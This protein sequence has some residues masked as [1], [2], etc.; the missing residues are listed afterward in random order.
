MS[1]AQNV[2]PSAD[3][4]RKSR[5]DIILAVVLLL[6]AAASF[7]WWNFSRAEGASVAVLI[8]GVETAEY[9][10]H[11]DR[12]VVITTGDNDEFK[13]V[14]VIRDG[15]VSVSEANCPD[16]ICVKT[17]AASKAGETIVCLPHKLVIEVAAAPSD[18]DLD[19]TV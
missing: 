11:E 17:R 14:M 6:A 15:K 19:M 18:S 9:A 2:N 12:E 3:K 4:K 13:N 5:N 16:S 1:R 7:L 10:L 8:N